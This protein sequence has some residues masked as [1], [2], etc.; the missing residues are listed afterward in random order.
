MGLPII[1]GVL[2][3]IGKIVLPALGKIGKGKGTVTGV[4]MAAVTTA[5]L[6]PQFP[7][8]LNEALRQVLEIIREIGVIVGLFCYGR[9]AGATLK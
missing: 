5:V 9:K 3:T 7:F 2:T 1:G 4:A 6:V 8:D